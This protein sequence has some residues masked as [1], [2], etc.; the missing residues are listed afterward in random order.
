MKGKPCL[1]LSVTSLPDSPDLSTLSASFP[2]PQNADYWR[3]L[4]SASCARVSCERVGALSLLPT[5]LRDMDLEAVS[6]TLARDGAGR[7]YI[8]DASGVRPLDFNLSHTARHAGCGAVFP[9]W[10]VGV[11]IEEPIPVSRADALA[12][13]YCTDGERAA[14]A[15]KLPFSGMNISVDFTLIWTLREAMAKYEGKGNPLAYDAVRPPR[16]VRLISG[17]LPDSGTRLTVCCSAGITDIRLA[18]DSL[19][20]AWDMDIVL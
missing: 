12:R 7:P 3:G 2:S 4:V 15:G 1:Y 5:L 18:E 16:G 10:S 14:L 17:K 6:M 11:D 19:C 9:P 20:P 13:R 8:T